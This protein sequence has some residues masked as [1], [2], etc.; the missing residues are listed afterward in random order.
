MDPDQGGGEG[1]RESEG[2][3]CWKWGARYGKQT[4]GEKRLVI[5]RFLFR[6]EG[7]T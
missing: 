3:K 7:D 6:G 4:E 5:L 2:K 1:K